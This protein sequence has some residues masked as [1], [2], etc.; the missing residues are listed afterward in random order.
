[1]A[2][3][4]VS[5]PVAAD[6]TRA[7]GP[8]GYQFILDLWE[9]VGAVS[10]QLST[11]DNNNLFLWAALAAKNEKD[12]L[13]VKSSSF[14]THASG[15]FICT[16]AIT[17]TLNPNPADREWVRLKRETANGPV[18]ISGTIDNDSSGYTMLANHENINLIYS[19][20]LGYWVIMQ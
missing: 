3:Q 13:Q 15:L 16:D 8:T 9:Y 20:S 19:Q 12:Y 4:N 2:I 18:V 11:L 7:V 1:M 6:W 14:T 5:P 10:D 17:A